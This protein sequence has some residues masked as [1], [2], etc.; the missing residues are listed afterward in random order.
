MTE[1]QIK[2]LELD[3]E[4]Y[5]KLMLTEEKEFTFHHFVGFASSL[6][7][8]YVG[9]SLL[10]FTDKKQAAHSLVHFYNRGFSHTI[11]AE[12]MEELALLIVGDPLI[13]YMIID[14]LHQK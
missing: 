10:S 5:M 4:K 9:S 7:N 14:R 2:M 11:T 13:N 3:F 8:F 12:D 1:K 6:I